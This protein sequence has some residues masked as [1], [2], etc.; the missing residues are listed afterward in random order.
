MDY[1]AI[2][3]DTERGRGRKV[4]VLV[5]ALLLVALVIGAVVRGF[6][7]HSSY[8]TANALTGSAVCVLVGPALRRLRAPS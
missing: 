2:I 6:M 4:V 8:S 7:G 5:L 3:R 1:G